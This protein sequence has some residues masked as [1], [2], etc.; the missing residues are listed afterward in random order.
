MRAITRR[1]GSNLRTHR[2]DQRG[3]R[4]AGGKFDPADAPFVDDAKADGKIPFFG[5]IH[6]RAGPFSP[7]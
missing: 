2:P 5:A 6:M 3:R 7:I 4:N 1:S